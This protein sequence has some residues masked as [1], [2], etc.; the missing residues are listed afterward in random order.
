MNWTHYHKLSTINDFI[1]CLV[2]VH[3]GIVELLEFGESY[4][5]RPLKLVKI[6][7]NKN[8]S[9]KPI[10]FIDGGIHAREWTSVSSTLYIINEL[11]ENAEKY[12]DFLEHYDILVLP[13][14]NPD[15]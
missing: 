11:A 2:H 12:S 10:V 5:K 13:I 1:D 7:A 3:S 6:S 8:A 9:S 15:G 14:L 4:E